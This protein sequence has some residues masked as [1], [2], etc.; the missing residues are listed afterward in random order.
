M[1]TK[2]IVDYNENIIDKTEGSRELYSN[3]SMR[4]NGLIHNEEF[5][6]ID[7]D[8]ASIISDSR[9][10]AVY[11]TQLYKDKDTLKNVIKH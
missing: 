1:N 5:D 4:L 8:S 11:V 6:D 10:L 2:N 9:N 7:V 3:N